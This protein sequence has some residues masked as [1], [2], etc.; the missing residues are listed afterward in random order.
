MNA[1]DLIQTKHKL[2]GEVVA[3]DKDTVEVYFLVPDKTKAKGKVWVYKKDWDT[4]LKSDITKHVKIKDKKKYPTYYREMGFKAWDGEIF[5]RTDVDI[6]KDE[7]LKTYPFPTGCDT[8]E[9]ED[10]YEFD[11]FVVPDEEAFTH[12]DPEIE[13]V[14]EF[15][16]AVHDFNKWEPKNKKEEWAKSFVENME[17]KYSKQDDNFQF[18][19]G[20][21]ID[22][23]HPPLAKKQKVAKETDKSEKIK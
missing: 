9:E 22:Y 10:E 16:R 8:D 19:K 14:Q 6:E 4:I 12:A 21:S 18:S 2:I 15:H 3:V 20:K 23:H 1:G 17:S 11:G 7:D 5:T 13:E